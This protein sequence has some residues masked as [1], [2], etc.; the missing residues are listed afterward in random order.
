MHSL[1]FKYIY[2]SQ[3]RT[4]STRSPY[5]SNSIYIDFKDIFHCTPSIQVT[6]EWITR[7]FNRHTYV[8]HLTSERNQFEI[9][10]IRRTSPV[11]YETSYN[12]LSFLIVWI[13]TICVAR[14]DS[15][16]VKVCDE[17][18][19]GSIGVPKSNVKEEVFVKSWFAVGFWFEA[20]H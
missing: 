18:M 11:R 7:P 8:A 17:I 2:K 3:K 1:V 15:T 13:W 20:K 5:N 10:S 4:L 12:M 6:K 16:A 9:F 14:S 19:L